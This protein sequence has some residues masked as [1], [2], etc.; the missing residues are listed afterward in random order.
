MAKRGKKTKTKP[1]KEATPGQKP[2]QGQQQPQERPAEERT[3]PTIWSP[4]EALEQANRVFLEQTGISP[5]LRT[6]IRQP[7]SSFWLGPELREIPI[8]L[9]DNGK[10]YQILAEM[11]GISKNDIELSV[12]PHDLRLCGKTETSENTKEKDYVRRERGYSM[13][14]RTMT[15][16]EE[17]NPDK[18]DA[19]LNEGILN[20]RIQKK[21]ATKINERKIPIKTTPGPKP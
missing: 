2:V 10:E 7:I 1:T 3:L 13:L 14:C 19:T 15:F 12:T 11:P 6:M 4:I 5:W 21:T 18:A 16:P 20:I 8:D 9:V 17:V